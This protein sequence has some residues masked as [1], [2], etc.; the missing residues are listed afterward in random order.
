MSVLVE[1]KEK[2]HAR[3]ET[4]VPAIGPL[5]YVDNI[6][7]R[8]PGT[9][10][11][12]HVNLDVRAGEVHVLF[13]ENGAGKTTLTKL[14]A[15]V[16]QPS[17]G[18]IFLNDEHIMIRS[19]SHA[20]SLGISMVFQ[21]F[22]LIPELTVEENLFL[23]SEQI[24]GPF[25]NKSEQRLQAQETLDR[26]GFD[27]NLTDK[28]LYLSRAEQQMVEI[29]KSFRTKPSVLL[30]DEP[31]ASITER[32]SARLFSLIQTL[33][34]EGI[35]IIY[36]T[37]KMNEI[38]TI[39]DRITILRD[40]Q[41]IDTLDVPDTDDNMLVTLMTGRRIE[42]V[43][44]VI[45]NNPQKTLLNIE[46]MTLAND[47]AHDVTLNVRAGEVVGV[48]GLVGSGKSRLARA[49]FGLEK[50][51]KGKITYSDEVVFD[52]QNKIDRI[53]PRLMLDRGM[54]YLPSDRHQ[55]GL[56]MV[57]SLRENI[58]LPSLGLAKF[59]N[60]FFLRRSNE[61]EF[62]TAISSQLE[63]GTTN[64]ELE[65][66]HFS[67][68]NQQKTM[69]AKGLVREGRLFVLDEPTTGVDIGA[70]VLIYRFIRDICEAGA[71][72]LIISSDLAEILH[73]T[74]RTYVMYRGG[75]VTELEGKEITEQNVLSYFFEQE[76]TS[77]SEEMQNAR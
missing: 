13:G 21:D 26:L 4:S 1:D 29:A 16:Y 66:E 74:H 25:L 19:I 57:Q 77:R 53:S 45:K 58:T 7:K 32:E 70:R 30:L 5:L 48:A 11:L 51:T 62:V 55:E 18:K 41:A 76:A 47:V 50:I 37:H 15:G 54:F 71:A 33:K 40:G 36:I 73:L 12:D 56:V 44:P 20:R 28:V 24:F 34:N 22:S 17:D 64:I 10:A 23:G 52:K 69:V 63:F 42:Q 6:S 35:A 9:L 8:F 72:V 14:I 43:F 61:K 65:L 27:L 38:R 59:F 39:G 68:G 31:T 67:G 46:N 2:P 60:G 75:L 49:A 3:P